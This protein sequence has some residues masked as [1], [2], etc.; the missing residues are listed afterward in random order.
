M[1]QRKQGQTLRE[2]TDVERALFEVQRIR[3]ELDG[4]IAFLSARVPNRGGRRG[5]VE[6]RDPRTGETFKKGR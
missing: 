5:P 6:V 1:M 4:V 3:K 2:T